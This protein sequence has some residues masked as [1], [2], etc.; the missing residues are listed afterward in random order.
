M[1]VSVTDLEVANV[2]GAR[3][4]RQV[5]R[6]RL[7]RGGRIAKKDF[8]CFYDGTADAGDFTG[9]STYTFE[10]GNSITMK[11]VGAWSAEGIGGDYEVL[12]GTGAYQGVT[13]T[14]RFDAVGDSWKTRT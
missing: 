6:R 5:D 7:L 13:G 10:N 4:G 2:P 11:F 8:V 1:D 9:Y 14:G 3:W 12:S